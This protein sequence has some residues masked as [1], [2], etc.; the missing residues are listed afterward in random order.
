[1]AVGVVAFSERA[2]NGGPLLRAGED[3]EL[4]LAA[5]GMG[6]VFGEGPLQQPGTVYVTTRCNNFIN[7]VICAVR[8]GHLACFII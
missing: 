7:I 5:P 8:E 4:R 2:E 1:M 3:E 6:V